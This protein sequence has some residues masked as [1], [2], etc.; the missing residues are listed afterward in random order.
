MSSI[1]DSWSYGLGSPRTIREASKI[2]DDSVEWLKKKYGGRVD[3]FKVPSED[4]EFRECKMFKTNP[5]VKP[6]E[7]SGPVVVCDVGEEL[8]LS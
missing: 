6:E 4:D 1:V 2:H 5:D 3:T 8:E 7:P